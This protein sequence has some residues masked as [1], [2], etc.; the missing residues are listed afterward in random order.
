MSRLGQGL[1]RLLGILF[2]TALCAC[3]AGPSDSGGRTSEPLAS[4]MPI[5]EKEAR[6]LKRDPETRIATL[7]GGCFWCTEA[8]FRE[9]RGVVSVEP[10]Y[11]G[12]ELENPSY[13]EVCRGDTG[14]VEVIQVRFDP[15]VLAYERLLEV[16]FQVHDPTT[17]DRQG[18]DVGPQYRSVIFF[19]DSAQEAQAEE[20]R[21]RAQAWWDAPVVTRIEP[22]TA[23]YPAE[24][25]HRAYYQRNS[26][27]PYCAF[28]IAPKL[29]KF[30]QGFASELQPGASGP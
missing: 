9:L 4:S 17:L 20:V 14:H 28:V 5:P 21:A 6:P 25:E 7:G 15:A 8:I 19:H 29:R 30:R 12:G 26:S 10:G 27:Q 2:L 23:F 18:A 13:E 16:F 11:S 22:F 1:L 3:S 24:A